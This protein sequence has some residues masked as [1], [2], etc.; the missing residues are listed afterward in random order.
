M[1]LANLKFQLSNGCI[2]IEVIFI[3][4]LIIITIFT[5]Y[6]TKSN[7]RQMENSFQMFDNDHNL[8]L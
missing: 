3:W 5:K 4:L 1:W 6:Y 2:V 8:K 7:L